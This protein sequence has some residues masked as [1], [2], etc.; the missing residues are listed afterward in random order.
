MGKSRITVTTVV[1]TAIKKTW[2]YS[3]EPEHITKWNNASEC[4]HTPFAE[5]DLRVLKILNL[6]NLPIGRFF[7]IRLLTSNSQL[8]SVYS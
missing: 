4:W 1:L 8:R 2:R 7:H 6:N 3:T 5:N